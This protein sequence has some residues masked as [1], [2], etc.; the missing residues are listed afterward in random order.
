M[1]L[2]KPKYYNKSWGIVFIRKKRSRAKAFCPYSK[3]MCEYYSGYTR[4]CTG[5]MINSWFGKTDVYGFCSYLNRNVSIFVYA[6]QK[7]I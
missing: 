1:S 3:E 4:M 6:P 5:I 7:T 2:L